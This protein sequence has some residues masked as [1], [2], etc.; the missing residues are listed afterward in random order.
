MPLESGQSLSHYRL[1]EKIGEG[2][3][4]VVWQA[5]DT[6]LGREVAIKVLPEA[7][8]SDPHRL[9]RFER[10][11]KLLAS[12]N[13]P[14]IAGLFGL[15]EAQGVRFLS[16]ELIHGEDLGQRLKRGPIPLDESLR[17]AVQ[18]AEGLEAAHE[19]GV[20]HRD[21]KPANIKLTP[22]GEVK[23]L[24]FG[25]AKALQDPVP[26]DEADLSQ[27]PTMTAA[28]TQAGG[29]LGTAA[30]MSPEQARGQ[31]ADRRTD[32]WAFGCVLYEMLTGASP[33]VG[34]TAS[35]SIGAVLHK[36]VDLDLLPPSTPAAVRR[37]LRRCLAKELRARLQHIGDVR[38][39]LDDAISGSGGALPVSTATTASPYRALALIGV[40]AILVVAALVAVP[41]ILDLD[42]ESDENLHLSIVQPTTSSLPPEVSLH[43]S[44]V[45]ISPDGSTVAYLAT[46]GATSALMVRNLSQPDSR[47]LPGTEGATVP[48]FSPDG[49]RI[50]FVSAG[51]LRVMP[52]E[53]ALP[54]EVCDAPNARGACWID[55]DT[56]LMAR[57][58][59]SVIDRVTVSTGEVESLTRL[60]DD[61][62]EVA[63]ETPEPIPGTGQFLF[64]VR[65]LRHGTTVGMALA[66]GD[67]ATGEHRIIIEDAGHGRY[68][69]E[70]IVYS[71]ADGSVRAMAFDPVRGE[72][73]GQQRT[74]LTGVRTQPLA[75]TSDLAL[76][77]S[78]RVAYMPGQAGWTD[79]TVTWRARD[80]S[81]EPALAERRGFTVARLSPDERFLAL[82]IS[83]PFPDLWRYDLS[84]VPP[85][86]L[87]LTDDGRSI[88]PVWS[89]DGS[90]IIH[91]SMRTGVLLLYRT[92]TDGSRESQLLFESPYRTIPES[93]SEDGKLFAYTSVDPHTGLD[94]WVLP[95][96][97]KGDA[98]LIAG[99][100]FNESSASFSPGGKWIAY[101]SD[102]SGA[103]E[104]YLRRADGTGGGHPASVGGGVDPLWRR[105]EVFFR[106]GDALMVASVSTDPE[107]R[108]GTPTE[109]FTGLTTSGPPVRLYDVTSD[110]SRVLVTLPQHSEAGSQYAEVQVVTNW[111]AQVKKRIGQ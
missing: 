33:F 54:R 68:A 98:R 17:L 75:W 49:S 47:L 65:R 4:G 67:V 41:L 21:L 1:A 104:I 10:E 39:E 72:T 95:L 58:G 74:V 26:G 93:W 78:G 80:G 19:S 11:A 103:Y 88:I 35:D 32:I 42:Q 36:E 28:A 66:L 101:Q 71:R 94:I 52:I 111:I 60:D 90:E 29:I 89:P 77:A 16:M 106:R 44:S 6:T 73:Q 30:Y 2:G 63:H 56:V 109:L 110:G 8:A 40:L 91:A 9:K 15:H 23:I 55:D 14:R 37:L 97:G 43:G 3:M 50:G 46:S 25:L 48:F 7:F 83:E 85:T 18:V 81:A 24:D 62:N 105:D 5:V 87:R 99:T 82:G 64:T 69:D 34:E 79:N 61:N 51:R 53:G 45:A 96:D 13:H 92:P 107:L 38:I 76:S 22:N 12:L 108:I 57:F 102:E 84:T 31:E 70:V 100:R 27:S 59:P 20:I 86:R